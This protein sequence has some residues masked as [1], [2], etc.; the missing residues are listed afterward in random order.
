MRDLSQFFRGEDRTSHYPDLL[1]E[2][3]QL[4]ERPPLLRNGNGW[5]DAGQGRL[6]FRKLLGHGSGSRHERG[7]KRLLCPPD[8]G[9]IRDH[10]DNQRCDNQSH[11]QVPQKLSSA[12]SI[13]SVW[14]IS[15]TWSISFVWV[16]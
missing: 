12:W 16:F 7:R 14:S 8:A 11:R 10:E 6:W 4:R 5:Q 2:Y 9:Q 3:G 15:L 1:G 13:R